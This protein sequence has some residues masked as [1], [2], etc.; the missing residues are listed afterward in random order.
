MVIAAIISV[1]VVSAD[2]LILF[3]SSIKSYMHFHEA[4]IGYHMFHKL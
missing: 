4:S 2:K 1:G 3:S